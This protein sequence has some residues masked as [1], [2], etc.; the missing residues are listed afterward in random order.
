ML[1][2]LV[3]VVTLKAEGRTLEVDEHFEQT[4]QNMQNAVGGYIE[5]LTL[6]EDNT[7]RSI[8][9]WLNEEGKFEGVNA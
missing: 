7:G 8:T 6:R 5:A 4:L 9:V 3:R 2:N 1:N